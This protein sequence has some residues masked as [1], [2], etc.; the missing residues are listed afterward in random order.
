[1]GAVTR[2]GET[3]RE[4]LERV[5]GW[6]IRK[7]LDAHRGRRA[8]TAGHLGITRGGLYKKMLLWSR[9][10]TDGVPIRNRERR[11]A[12]P[13]KEIHLKSNT[14]AEGCGPHRFHFH[15]ESSIYRL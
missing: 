7:S 5:E 15:P 8:A 2:E 14:Y 3:L 11:P 12:D 13:S 9:D 1:V 10:R 4:A 6:L